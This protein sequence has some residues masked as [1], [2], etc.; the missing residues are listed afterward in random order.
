MPDKVKLE[1]GM[2]Q[3]AASQGI[4]FAQFIEDVAVKDWG[5]EETDYRGKS[6]LERIKLK[7]EKAAAGL[8]IPATT[9]EK[10]LEKYDVHAW[11][12]QTDNI[13]KFFVN[14]DV[15]TL[16]P[17]YISNRIYSAM[18]ATSLVEP[19]LAETVIIKGLEFKKIYLED[20][21]PQRQLIRRARG[22]EFPKTKIN[23]ADQSVMLAKYG[24]TL[25]FD[26]EVLQSS[27]LGLYNIVLN[28]IGTQLG[29]DKTDELIYVLINGDGNSNGLAS[30]Q[31]QT[32]T[33]S[34][35]I[36]KK[37]IIKLNRALPTPYKL[38]K[39]F[40]R[41]D[42]L[43]EY[44]DALSDMTNPSAQWG[45]TTIKLAEA[46][47]WDRSVLTSDR[48]IGVDSRYAVGLVTNDTVMLTE[49]EKIITKQKVNTVCS[50][51]L[52]Y[53]VIDQNAIGC[54]DIEH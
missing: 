14:A 1:K 3:D 43:I 47:E 36:A 40:G 33:T 23:V 10:L 13:S 8:P 16:F 22:A 21:E 29:I 46:Y 30:A 35:A 19:F 32:T 26:Y 24:R 12:M 31:T 50:T 34:T 39:F 37:D 49:T 25:E 4:S 48:F 53:N 28:R 6:P 9:F 27:P 42:Y 41:K 18:L 17:E 5:W 45:A 38:N 51:R 11:G 20:T 54:L 2:Y 7:R 44:D 52:A 15:A